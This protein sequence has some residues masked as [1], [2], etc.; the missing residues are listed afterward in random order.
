MANYKV[1]LTS[2]KVV[3]MREMSVKL[4][5]E[6]ITSAANALGKDASGPIF[7]AR[8]QDEMMKT[9]LVSV[10]GKN[11]SGAEKEDL[12]QLFTMAEYT[13]LGKATGDIM[14]VDEEKKPK[15]ELITASA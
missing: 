13:Q 6:C 2:G 10:N 9:L 5:N 4:K 15:I 14:G 12:D 3:V 8:L 11:P 1:T 7:Q